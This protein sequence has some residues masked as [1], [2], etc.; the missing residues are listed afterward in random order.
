MLVNALNRGLNN[1]LKGNNYNGPAF[2]FARSSRAALESRDDEERAW[3]KAE[4]R[5]KDRRSLTRLTVSGNYVTSNMVSAFV[6]FEAV[7]REISVGFRI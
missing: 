2:R 3:L 6:Q 7:G 4:R 5:S 1:R